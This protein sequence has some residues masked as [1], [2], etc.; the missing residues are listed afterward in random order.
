MTCYQGDMKPFDF[1]TGTALSAAATV[2]LSPIPEVVI[3]RLA[4]P[5]LY[6]YV[7]TTAAATGSITIV[8]S[9]KISEFSTA[10]ASTYIPMT[11]SGTT[12]AFGLAVMAAQDYSTMKI[13]SVKNDLNQAVTAYK[14]GYTGMIMY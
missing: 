4:K 6:A 13:I 1:A 2:N 9:L 12:S 3:A 7:T 10:T 14:V 11:A 5:I 8:Y